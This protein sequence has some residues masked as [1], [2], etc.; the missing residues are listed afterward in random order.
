MTLIT[1]SADTDSTDLTNISFT[2][3]I[4]NTYKLYIFKFYDVNPVTDHQYFSFNG[5]DDASSW[6]YDITKTSS[7]FLTYHDEADANTALTYDA[8]K[9]I[10][11]QTGY[12]IIADSIGSGGDE[13]AAGELFLFNPSNTT[14]VKHWYS[15]AVSYQYNDYFFEQF[16]A[17]FFNTTAA[18]T[19]IDFKMTS[20]NM[21]AVIKLYGVG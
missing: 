16:T 14:Y 5:S 4:D 19:A 8:N 3:G 12:Q 11:N 2:T 21:D 20:G 1:N 6:A 18:I 9:D 10:L 13:S 17:G 7:F 15:R